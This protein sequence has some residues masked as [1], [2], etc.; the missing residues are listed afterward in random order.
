MMKTGRELPV[1]N[2][3]QS[4]TVIIIVFCPSRVS[5][6]SAI[7][8]APSEY[9]E[10]LVRSHLPQHVDDWRSAPLNHDVSLKSKV[11]GEDILHSLV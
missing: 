5:A 11:I 3:I 6:E 8:I 1:V 4:F 9:L 2:D 10:Q 7:E